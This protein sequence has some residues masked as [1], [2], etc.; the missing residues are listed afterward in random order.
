MPSKLD[1]KVIKSNGRTEILENDKPLRFIAL[2]VLLRTLIWNKVL[3]MLQRID[4]APSPEKCMWN[5][6][7][8]ACSSF[9]ASLIDG[10]SIGASSEQE[11]PT[12]KTEVTQAILISLM[13]P[14][15]KVPSSPP[16][17]S[18]S[19]C[20]SIITLTLSGIAIWTYLRSPMASPNSL[21][22]GLFPENI[23]SNRM[24]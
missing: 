8:T 18:G 23:S 13:L 19:S 3:W 1:H 21:S 4:G 9:R 7:L 22:V 10:W 14:E 24:P 15:F 11:I 12:C 20:W 5:L 2:A 16:L 17:V 6:S